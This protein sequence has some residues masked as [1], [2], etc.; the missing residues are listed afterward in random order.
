MG[1]G[2]LLQGILPT[3]GLNP[4][5]LQCRWIL[6]CLSHQA[7]PTRSCLQKSPN[8]PNHFESAREEPHPLHLPSPQRVH[9]P[10]DQLEHASKSGLAVFLRL[11][12]ECEHVVR[13]KLGRPRGSR[14]TV[15]FAFW[16][17]HSALRHSCAVRGKAG[18]TRAH[19]GII[20]GADAKWSLERGRS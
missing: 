19:R 1:S 13:E 3:Q 16:E 9:P 8:H 4:G 10:P 11:G 17:A 12:Q 7:S 2:S 18:S 20:R 6:Y 15:A 5:L 14:F